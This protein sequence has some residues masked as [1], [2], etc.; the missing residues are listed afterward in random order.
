MVSKDTAGCGGFAKREGRP[1]RVIPISS[2][3][4]AMG[5][6]PAS[7]YCEYIKIIPFDF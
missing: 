3:A 7:K 4:R 5:M 2:N 1:N 6:H